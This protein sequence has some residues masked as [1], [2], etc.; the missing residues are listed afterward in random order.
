MATKVNQ[1]IRSNGSIKHG[2]E[3]FI[4]VFAFGKKLNIYSP[5]ETNMWNA[6]V[7]VRTRQGKEHA[8]EL[9]E[10]HFG[11]GHEKWIYSGEQFTNEMKEQRPDGCLMT[12]AK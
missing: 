6:W 3:S 2:M 7:E 10:E 11:S 4:F 8:K 9:F 1:I 12:I 5:I